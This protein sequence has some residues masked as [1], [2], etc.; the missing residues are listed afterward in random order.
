MKKISKKEL[1]SYI[2]LG[3]AKNIDCLSL[4]EC[5][6]LNAECDFEKYVRNNC[7]KYK[8]VLFLLNITNQPNFRRN[9][10]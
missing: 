4:E 1:K 3:L 2:A 6:A 7:K 8:S 9:Q 10:L 5:R